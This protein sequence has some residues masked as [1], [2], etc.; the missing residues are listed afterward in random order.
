MIRP[1]T[2]DVGDTAGKVRGANFAQL[3]KITH[4]EHFITQVPPDLKYGRTA[5]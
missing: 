2:A 5:K 4:E 3:K 1:K